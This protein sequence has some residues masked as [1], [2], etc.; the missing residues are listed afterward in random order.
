MWALGQRRGEGLEP[1]LKDNV[2]Q[3]SARFVP[4][5]NWH[6]NRLSDKT[7]VRTSSFFFPLCIPSRTTK[8]QSQL[9]I[10][11][12]KSFTKCLHCLK[13]LATSSLSSPP[14]SWSFHSWKWWFTAVPSGEQAVAAPKAAHLYC[15]CGEKPCSE[16]GSFR[17][18]RGKYLPGKS[19]RLSLCLSGQS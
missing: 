2:I 10:Y 11:H 8:P 3:Y 12:L 6:A 14:S 5:T 19:T 15:L 7:F 4:N 1:F 13:A 16:S 18:T 17:K 9:V